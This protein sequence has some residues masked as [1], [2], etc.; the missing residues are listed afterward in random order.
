MTD[1]LPA[2]IRVAHANPDLRPLLLPIIKEAQEFRT[3][4]ALDKY[5]NDHP[6]ADRSRHSIKKTETPKPQGETKGKPKKDKTKKT[7]PGGMKPKHTSTRE[8]LF[9][10]EELELLPVVQQP[11]TTPDALF[12]QAEST[13]EDQLKWLDHGEGIDKAIGAT[14]V[15]GDQREMP[16]FNKPGPLVMI[17]PIKKMERSKE[18]VES[19]YAGDWSRLIDVVRASI[20]VDHPD[21]IPDLLNKLRASGMQIARRPNDRFSHPTEAGY[22][23]LSLSVRY[24]N[25]HIGELQLHLKEILKVK[26]QAHSIFKQT[27]T[28][29]ARAKKEGRTTMTAE[30]QKIVDEGNAEMKRIFT[31]AYDKALGVNT[32]ERKAASMVKA[33]KKKVYNWNG[34]PAIWNSLKFPV[35]VDTNGK[36]HTIYELDRFFLSASAISPSSF[37]KLMSEQT[38]AHMKGQKQKQKKGALR[39]R[40]IRTAHAAG[41]GDLQKAILQILG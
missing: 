32:E 2:M 3:Q 10:A 16:D 39:E 25:G 33:A 29:A 17:G 40:L 12:A 5:L 22:R 35:W 9:S 26:E 31:S 8:K 18:K 30:E 23:D 24:P 27:R 4:D 6:K 20:A 37:K 38:S 36:E 7:D 34:V 15:R 28:I 21:Q 1:L 19:D 41:P 14:V 11:A 13:H